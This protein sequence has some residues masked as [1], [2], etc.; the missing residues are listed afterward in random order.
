M[1]VSPAKLNC[2]LVPGDVFCD[3]GRNGSGWIAL[4]GTEFLAFSGP[5]CACGCTKKESGRLAKIMYQVSSDRSKSR[6]LTGTRI[7]P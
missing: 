6:S 4:F 5:R 3:V 7:S 1:A 2:K